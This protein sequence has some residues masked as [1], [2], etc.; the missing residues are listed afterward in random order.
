MF[1]I[2]TQIRMD[3]VVGH[4]FCRL[5]VND[6]IFYY[7]FTSMTLYRMIDSFQR[8]GDTCYLSQARMSLSLW[9]IADVSEQY[10]LST[11]F[12]FYPEE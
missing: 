9:L 12:H 10:T 5:K 2:M 11:T 4:V 7:G 6:Y 8:F 3:I 1:N